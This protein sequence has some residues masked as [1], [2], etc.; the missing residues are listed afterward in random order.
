MGILYYTKLY[1]LNLFN[2]SSKG[3]SLKD[4]AKLIFVYDHQGAGNQLTLKDYESGIK[5]IDVIT[6]KGDKLPSWHYSPK[7]DS[8]LAKE[9]TIYWDWYIQNINGKWKVTYCTH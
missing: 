9:I 7:K 4:A 5:L 6:F 3:P 8:K 2:R 1:S